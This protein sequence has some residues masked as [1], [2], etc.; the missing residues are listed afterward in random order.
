MR[1]PL[2][3][4]LAMR[5]LEALAAGA[6]LE[7]VGDDPAMMIDLPAWCEASGHRLLALT[8]EGGAVRALV[9]RGAE[10]PVPRP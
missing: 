3:V 10:G 7:I 6:R 2:P 1:C 8:R 9:E 5:A 4:R